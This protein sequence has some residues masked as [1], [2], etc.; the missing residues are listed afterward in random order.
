MWKTLESYLHVFSNITHCSLLSEYFS[1][2]FFPFL[3]IGSA[4]KAFEMLKKKHSR[5][6]INS[7]KSSRSGAGTRDIEAAKKELEEFWFLYWLD[8][9]IR[10]RKTKTNI[11]ELSLEISESSNAADEL[12]NNCYG[13]DESEDAGFDAM[14]E[15]TESFT[16]VEESAPSKNVRKNRQPSNRSQCHWKK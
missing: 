5:K 14:N 13:S 6:R 2:D 10:P 11:P 16:M 4:A 1:S 7:Q 3:F 8:S 15:D 9:F 12:K